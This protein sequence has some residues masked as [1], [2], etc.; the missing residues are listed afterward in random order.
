MNNQKNESASAANRALAQSMVCRVSFKAVLKADGHKLQGH[1]TAR[2]CI[3]PF[4]VG[5]APTFTV[6]GRDTSAGCMTCEWF[7]DVVDYV[8]RFHNL[9]SAKALEFLEQF[10]VIHPEAGR[11]VFNFA[12]GSRKISNED[13]AGLQRFLADDDSY[14]VQ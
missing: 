12:F 5:E 13:E 9:D 14:S 4:H 6:N 1:A 3:C 7:G 8:M 10:L 2:R 11:K